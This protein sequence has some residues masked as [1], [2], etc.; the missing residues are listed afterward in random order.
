M[1]IKMTPAWVRAQSVNVSHRP[2]CRFCFA[3]LSHFA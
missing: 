3:C 1:G 2:R